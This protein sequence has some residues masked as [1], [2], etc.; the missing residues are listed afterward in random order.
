MRDPSLRWERRLLR[1]GARVIAG[2]DE[3]GRGA[4]AGPIVAAAVV[5]PLQQSGLAAVL[6][7]VRDSKQMSALQRDRW[8]GEILGLAEAGLG[9]ASP[10]EVDAHGVI[11][12]TRLAMARALAGLPRP[13]DHLLIDYLRLPAVALPQ[14][15][16]TFGD[17]LSLSIAAASVVAKVARDRRMV[18]LDCQHPGFGFAH[19]KGYGTEEHRAALQALGPS[20]IHRFSYVPVAARA[21]PGWL[22]PVHT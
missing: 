16:L 18:E 1:R 22:T 14:T 13:P 12:A 11:G 7:G 4:W 5:L 8:Q 6:R 21:F 10:E 17:Q 20:A 2:L 9:E 19:H 3:V 15:A